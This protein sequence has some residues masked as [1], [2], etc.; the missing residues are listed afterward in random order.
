MKKF[1]FICCLCLPLFLS[2]QTHQLKGTVTDKNH[3]PIEYAAIMMQSVDSAYICSTSTDSLGRFVLPESRTM[4]R[5]VVQQ[6]SYQTFISIFSDKDKLDIQLTEKENVLNE[7]VVKANRPLVKAENGKLSYDLSVLTGNKVVN[8][9]YEALTK[10]PGISENKGSLELT[11]ASGLT[12]ILNGHPTTMTAEQLKTLLQSMPVSRVEKAEVMYSAPPQYHIRGAAINVVLRRANSYSFQGE[13]KA[14]YENQY[15]SSYG[16]GGNI[17]ITSPK[18]A[19]DLSYGINNNENMQRLDNYSRH[20][21]YNKVYDINQSERISDKGWRH[22]LRSAVELNLSDKSNLDISYNAFFAPNGKNECISNGNFQ[23]SVSNKKGDNQ[24]HNLSAQYK[25]GFGLNIG[26]DYTYYHSS[27][28]QDLNSQTEGTTKAFNLVNSQNIN[29]IN[30]TADQEHQLKRNWT[31]GYGASYSYA[32]D[33]DNQSYLE[34]NGIDATDTHSKLEEQTTD[35]YLRIGKNYQ[36]G[37][38]FSLSATGEYYTIGSY[39]KWAFFPQAS[40]TYFKTPKHIFQATLSSNKE[41]PSYWQLQP[42]ITYT[43]AYMVTQGTPGLKPSS[44]LELSASYILSQRYVFTFFANR[45][46]DYFQQAAYQSSKELMLIYKTQNWDYSQQWGVNAM[47]PFKIKKWLNSELTL[48]GLNLRQ[49]CDNYFD[50]PFDR[51]RWIGVISIDNT[52][53]AGKGISFEVNGKWQSK[54]IQG[55]YDIGGVYQIDA[56]A[57]WS[58]AK[59]RATLSAR[60]NDVFNS[61]MPKVK[62]RF[63][64]QY[65][66]MNTNYFTRDL[67]IS[68]VYRFGGYKEKKH[69]EVDTSR[70][71]H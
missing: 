17:R 7:V 5:L 25:S 64:G 67:T 56:A 23:Q 51:N 52:F 6:L 46:T 47:L 35:F 42:F 8:N 26:A 50:I 20:T 71:G 43:D 22:N 58:F 14:G 59:D 49:K 33:K 9:V 1:L 11:G 62:V 44:K 38:S 19:F 2:A 21:L 36:S 4:F 69:K 37:A 66:D 57:K 16:T 68:F 28:N 54:A 60:L 12:I 10:L 24:M 70:F 13:I 41:Y 27:G 61:G 45:I 55:T 48:T 53:N 65:L 15:F 30:L 40:L 39:H 32:N 31:L 29:R 63:K 18:A 3:H 34:K